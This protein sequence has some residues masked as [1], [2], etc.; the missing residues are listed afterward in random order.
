VKT[1]LPLVAS[2][3]FLEVSVLI[4]ATAMY[5]KGDRPFAIFFSSKPGIVF[6]IAA[7][8]VLLAGTAGIRQ[9]LASTP[10][11]LKHFHLVVT[12]NLIT[13]LLVVITGEI[14]IRAWSRSSLEGETLG[15]RLLMP[16]SWEKVALYNRQ[17]WERRSANALSYVVYDDLMGWTLGRNTKR[18]NRNILYWSSA[19]GIRAQNEGVTFSNARGKKR[20]ALVGDSYTYGEDVT[21]EDTWG[22]LLEKE[23]G[24]VQVL[25]FGVSGYGVD[26]A[27]LRYEKDAR[28]WNPQIVIFGLMDHDLQRTMNVYPWIS[29][30]NWMVPFSKPRFILRDREIIRLNVPPLAPD[31]IFGRKSITELPF[32]EYDR[33]YIGRD[34]EHRLYDVSYLAR[35]FATKFPRW[36]PEHPDVSNEALVS[37]NAAIMQHFFRSAEQAGMIPIV[38]YF[39]W[40]A[41]LERAD[42]G[43]PNSPLAKQVLHQAGIPYTDTTSCLFELNA[44]DRFLPE[45][46][47]YTAQGHAAVAKC[48]R[49]VVQQALAQA[50]VRRNL[51]D[52]ETH[53]EVFRYSG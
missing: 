45:G 1:E 49:N 10:T 16:K 40:K 11:Q 31:A 30:L 44:A 4:I 41:E 43:E 21:Y 20:I 46:G 52:L 38:V 33:G 13:V 14:A 18:K 8:V 39:P 6:I 28:V 24:E 19:E 25:N 47:H 17:L 34:W 35:L 37:V 53:L 15:G 9:Y 7:A 29:Y 32:L 26:Q 50:F 27:Y 22:F 23:F 48:L 3:F 12:M 36:S 5:M 51:P 42:R 2:L